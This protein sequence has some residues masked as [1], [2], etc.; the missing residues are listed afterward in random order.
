MENLAGVREKVLLGVGTVLLAPGDPTLMW[1]QCLT[2]PWLGVMP[3]QPLYAQGKAASSQ[4]NQQ[5]AASHCNPHD[6][7][8]WTTL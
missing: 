4:E 7:V 2:V 6:I 3:A 5:V 1:A 8:L